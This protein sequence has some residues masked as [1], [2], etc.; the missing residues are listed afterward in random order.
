MCSRGTSGELFDEDSR[1]AASEAMR[2]GILHQLRALPGSGRLL[3][4]RK[5]LKT[6]LDKAQNRCHVLC[7][8]AHEVIREELPLKD[9]PR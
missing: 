8:L 9:C 7:P 3:E 2:N 1:I 6:Y 4:R 5:S